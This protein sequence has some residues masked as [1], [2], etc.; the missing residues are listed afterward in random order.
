MQDLIAE[1]ISVR[2]RRALEYL[3]DVRFERGTRGMLVEFLF[4][5]NPFFENKV[6]VD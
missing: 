2:D 1:H 5:D 3:V 6:R 4:R